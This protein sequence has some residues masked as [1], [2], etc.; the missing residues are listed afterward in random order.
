MALFPVPLLLFWAHVILFLPHWNIYLPIIVL[1]LFFTTV[2]ESL[3]HLC[4]CSQCLTHSRSTVNL[5]LEEGMNGLILPISI[6]QAIIC[7]LKT[8]TTLLILLFPSLSLPPFHPDSSKRVSLLVSSSFSLPFSFDLST[9][10]FTTTH[11]KF[12]SDLQ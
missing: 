10:A 12:T 3:I 8:K 1:T 6:E 2:Y 11:I 5:S 7:D 9:Q 4:L